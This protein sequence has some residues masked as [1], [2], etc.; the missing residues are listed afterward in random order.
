MGKLII[1]TIILIHYHKGLSAVGFES[2]YGF[3]G[4]AILLHT[5][6]FRCLG[7]VFQLCKAIEK[8]IRLGAEEKGGGTKGG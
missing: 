6:R 2:A 3:I 1:I 8:N 4:L 5:L 7:D